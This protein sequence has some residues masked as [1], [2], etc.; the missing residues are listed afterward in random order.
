VV[1]PGFGYVFPAIRGVQA[2]R[3]YYVCM[4]P[5]RLI[6]RIFSFD[7][8]ELPP[9][10]RAQR[11][12]NKARIPELKTYILENPTTYVFSSLTVSVDA[13]VRFESLDGSK[14]AFSVGR[15]HVPM[16]ARFI[17]ND[18]Q[19]RRAGIEAAMREKAE[20]GDETIS[21][22]FFLDLGLERCQ[23]MFAD[24]NRHA[25][26]PSTS[27]GLLYE[28]RD[29]GAMLTKRLVLECPVFRNLVEMERTT[30]SPRSRRL[31]TLSAVHAATRALFSGREDEL[32]AE[33]A[34]KLA[35]EYWEALAAV[36]PE[37]GAVLT[38]KA[39]SGEVRRDF[40]HSHG[41]ALQALGRAGNALHRRYP[42]QWKTRL[43]ALGE[44]N[45]SRD[46][47]ALWEGRMMIGGRVSKAANNI[48]LTT[49]VI[50]R[51]LGLDLS[52]EEQ[53]AEDAFARGEHGTSGE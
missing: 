10:L 40:I 35:S 30:L 32:G 12:L 44:I 6:P 41:I 50:K 39:T 1:E 16:D 8:E 27:L 43:A 21:V 47:S 34:L 29:A 20:L 18:G 46:N 52:P 48:L 5:L 23:Q 14:E 38:H 51:A 9:E 53:R 17:I 7:E 25:I 15:L 3:E 22:V 28:H 19:H 2:S 45:W 24:L 13:R 36:L 49:N 31:F 11:L 26:R 42:K 4:V 37:W 33:E